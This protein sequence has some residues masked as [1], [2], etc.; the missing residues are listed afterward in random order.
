MRFTEL[1][2][3]SGQAYRVS[4]LSEGV[5]FAARPFRLEPGRGVRVELRRY[6][7]TQE[8]KSLVLGLGHV[9]I[10]LK[11]KRV[12][13]VEQLELWQLAEA[14]FRFPEEGL[15]LPLPEGFKALQIEE[16][17]GDPRLLEDERGLRLR[18]ALMPGRTT[19]LFAYDLP[20][21]GGEMRFS[22]PIPWKVARFRVVTEAVEGLRLDVEGMPA[23]R[24]HEVGGRPMWIT[25][26]DRKPSD[27]PLDRLTVRLLGLPGP[28]PVR[29][30]GLLAAACFA[31]AGSVGGS[32]RGRSRRRREVLAERLAAARQEVLAE[33]V[34]LERERHDGEV[35]PQYY[36][37][38]L[39]VL[40]ERLAW[41]LRIEAQL[42]EEAG[43][44]A[45][46]GAPRRPSRSEA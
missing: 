28:G 35:G 22:H 41:I 34:A 5:R 46:A 12:R 42:A 33:R 37:H 8:G 9:E 30:L 23:P 38:R 26:L 43:R 40:R 29:W 20:I 27:P 25:E 21:E 19:L 36:A 16:R 4:A 32:L 10:T 7:V 15:L 45:G 1:A 3:G 17:M 44:G 11:E 14:A 31:L 39:E 2:S 18:G 24:R 6:P 13:V